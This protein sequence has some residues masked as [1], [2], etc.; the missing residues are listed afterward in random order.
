MCD[1]FSCK[2]VEKSIL[3]I[4]F[5][6]LQTCGLVVHVALKYK[7]IARLTRINSKRILKFN[8]KNNCEIQLF[9]MYDG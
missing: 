4:P 2:Y 9:N 7:K 8:M 1:C 5:C 3:Q 6:T